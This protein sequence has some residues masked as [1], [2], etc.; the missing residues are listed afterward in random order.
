MAETSPTKTKIDST[1]TISAE[2]LGMVIVDS[3]RGCGQQDVR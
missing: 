3:R 2:S 1:E